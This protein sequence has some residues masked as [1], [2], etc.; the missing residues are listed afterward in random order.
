MGAAQVGTSEGNRRPEKE[1]PTPKESPAG[2]EPPEL[3]NDPTAPV[4]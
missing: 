2:T 4:V 1:A 3:P